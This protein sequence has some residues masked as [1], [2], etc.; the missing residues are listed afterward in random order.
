MG[1]NDRPTKGFCTEWC[2]PYLA[3]LKALCQQEGL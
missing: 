1:M 3:L 2:T